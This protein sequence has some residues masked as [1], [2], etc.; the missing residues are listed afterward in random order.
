MDMTITRPQPIGIHPLPAGYLILPP[1]DAPDALTAIMRGELPPE[2]PAA[3]RF[4]GVALKG[5]VV[6]ALDLLAADDCACARYNRFVLAGSPSD[7]AILK[8]LLPTEW[9]PYLDAVAYTMGLID[10][11][12]T[13]GDAEGELRAHLLLV[14]ASQ[15]LEANQ[16]RAAMGLLKDAVE[17]ANGSPLFRAQLLGTLADVRRETL[18]ADAQGIALYVEA[19]R[20]LA[21]SPLTIVQGGLWLNLGISYQERGAY[22]AAARAY[23]DALRFVTRENDPEAFALA[24][25]N[26]ALT[27]LAMPMSEA[28]DQLRSAVAISALREALTIYSREKYPLQWASTQLNLANALQYLPSSHP[29]DNL[30]EAVRLYEDLYAVRRLED[31]PLGYARLRANQGNALA[32]LGIFDHARTNLLEAQAIFRKHGD[33]ESAEAITGVL[34]Q[35]PV[36]QTS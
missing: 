9:R 5:D 33:A 30:A 21:N 13:A 14:Q 36:G 25:N 7:Y 6:G 16:A 12:P 2:V 3:W 15:H 22:A 11:A 10:S 8:D 26:L 17:A 34:S 4:Y 32:H 28:G 1:A 20:L 23:Q 35:F 18:G 24:Q 27:Y 31:D 19:L 29:A